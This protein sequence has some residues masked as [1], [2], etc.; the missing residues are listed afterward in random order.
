MLQL[1]LDAESLDDT[2]SRLI[3]N[4][5]ADQESTDGAGVANNKWNAADV[6]F[7]KKL[8]TNVCIKSMVCY[9]TWNNAL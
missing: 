3:D 9:S 1:L 4:E 8:T 7:E 6:H 5:E 2:D